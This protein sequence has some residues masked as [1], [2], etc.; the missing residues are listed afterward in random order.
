MSDP[1][2]EQLLLDLGR[3]PAP[4]LDNFLPGR[5]AELLHALAAL[6]TSAKADMG[7]RFLY[8]WGASGSGRSH[9][10]R[11]VSADSTAVYW[12]CAEPPGAEITG[13]AANALQWHG[14]TKLWAI[15]DVQDAGP[16]EQ[17]ALFSLINEVR[18]DPD[19]RAAMVLAGDTAPGNLS[20]RD[21][22]RTRLAW[23]LVFQV[24][25]LSDDEKD[26]ALTLRAGQRGLALPAEVRRY[27]LSHCSRDMSSLMHL[28][29]ALDAFAMQ[30]HR[31]VTLPLVR[32]FSQELSLG[33]VSRSAA[34]PFP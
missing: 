6:A 31:A 9:L 3:P 11:A 7:E 12:S 13:Q 27:L 24:H 10:L 29:D 22:L 33:R 19:S 17:I 34:A 5:N 28:V 8:L 25:T 32:E 14:S 1:L 18:A 30:R 2:P 21:D 20:L 23:G 26:A 4:T 16:A 15:D